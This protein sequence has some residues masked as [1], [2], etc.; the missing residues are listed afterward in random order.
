M[1][2][3]RIIMDTIEGFAEQICHSVMTRNITVCPGAVKE[4]GDI[5]IPVLTNFILSPEYVCN[6]I[7]ESCNEIKY[8]V[9]EASLFV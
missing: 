7:V 6:N 5:M 9:M 8:E 1:L 3:T 4:M 2:K